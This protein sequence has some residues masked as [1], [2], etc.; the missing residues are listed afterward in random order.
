MSMDPNHVPHSA[1]HNQHHGSQTL[2]LQQTEGEYENTSATAPQTIEIPA[3]S[4]HNV[5]SAVTTPGY[6]YQSPVSTP[7]S[8][9]KRSNESKTVSEICPVPKRIRVAGPNPS[10]TAPT[11][12][13]TSPT[14]QAGP[15]SSS[16]SE[17][18]S[19]DRSFCQRKPPKIARSRSLPASLRTSRRTTKK[20]PDLAE[21]KPPVTL[22]TLK[23]LDLHEIYR[24]PK[25]RHD[26]VF[27]SQLHFRPNLDGNRGRKKREQADVYWKLVLHECEMLFANVRN[28]QAGV[29][30]MALKLPILFSTMRDILL[31]L[32]PKS[33]RV[34]V[35]AALDPPLLIQQLE[36][37]VLDFKK[38]SEWLACVLKAHCAPM[39]DQWVEQ[40][41]SRVAYG[42]ENGKTS[43]FVDGLKMVFGI[44]EAMK[45]DVANHQI[46]TL[47]PHL[48]STAVHFEQ[49]YF[50][51]KIESGRLSMAEPRDWYQR[52]AAANPGSTDPYVIF[53]R[54][55]TEML[56]PSKYATFPGTFQ[57]DFE[58]LEGIRDDIREAT[59]LKVAILYFR[60]H[61]AGSKRD[62]DQA[63]IN[64]LRAQ[65]LAILSEE[66]GP[67]RWIKGS[68]AVALHIA[69]AANEFN[70]N[71]GL[72]DAKTVDMAEGWFMKHLRVDS[73]IYGLVERE[74]VR[75]ITTL[76]LQVMKSWSS[77]STSP[78]MQAA[79]LTGSSFELPTIS[80]RISHIA[81]L[82]WRIF[83][84]LYT[85]T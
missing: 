38:L 17:S 84:K 62:L 2:R 80:Q 74:V 16:G 64:T 75:D 31:T 19:L 56:T 4:G 26:V 81:F 24:N 61:T 20:T 18:S 59:C 22:S 14:S 47:R 13:C 76:V 77:L 43:A 57:F 72:V 32:V 10:T 44:L 60:Q 6:D 82:H 11:S 45:L 66:E 40:M 12:A 65:L 30:G 49:G 8:P 34:D 33:D 71:R 37:G 27:D 85:T 70:G 50:Q 79:A 48:V 83:G 53:T 9:A 73:N 5:P 42:V 55:T 39:R 67:Y 68:D 1:R 78:I 29:G 21:H 41:V 52:G 35:E 25:L 54:A 36:Y 7:P 46:R 58:R 28:R 15:E 3:T 23:E 63:T 69:Q 51:E